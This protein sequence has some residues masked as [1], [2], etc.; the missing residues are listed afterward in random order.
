[1]CV[2]QQLIESISKDLNIKRGKGESET[3]WIARVIYSA[4]A[5]NA[6][7]S[8]WDQQDEDTSITHFKKRCN[9]QLLSYTRIYPEF[10]QN[11]FSSEIAKKYINYIYDLYLKTGFLLH[12]KNHVTNSKRK[13]A[14][15]NDCS[16]V[17]SPEPGEDLFMSG[18]GYY[19]LNDSMENQEKE[20]IRDVFNLCKLSL[21]EYLDKLRQ[22]QVFKL[23][24]SHSDI[25][26]LRLEPPFSKG[27]WKKQKDIARLSLLRIGQPGTY[28]Y[29]LYKA[30]DNEIL[31]SQ[32]PE[33][34][35]IDGNYRMISW[36]LLNK[37]QQ[38]TDI[39][40]AVSADLVHVRLNYLL[41]I[42]EQLFFELFSWPANITTMSSFNRTM[43]INIFRIMKAEFEK[44]GFRFLGK[45][46]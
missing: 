36:G 25:D 6:Y 9:E 32:L 37:Y 35:V 21:S 2:S 27:Y 44:I 24:E 14:T 3:D 45:D 20:N 41:P 22:R 4:I 29:Y 5:K 15:I 7:C 12:K 40:Y 26:Y 1:M 42:N 33:W 28:I 13:V 23:L 43:D 38:A 10:K 46:R 39:E 18:L 11:I 31:A 16:L 30:T 19:A 17:R 34:M 8:L